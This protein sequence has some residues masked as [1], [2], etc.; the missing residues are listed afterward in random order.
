MNFQ[1]MFYTIYVRER[2]NSFNVCVQIFRRFINRC[3]K[4]EGRRDWV[5]GLRYGVRMNQMI[6][7]ESIELFKTYIILKY[8]FMTQNWFGECN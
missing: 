8:I 1:S 4:G 6:T 7:L 2:S 3:L 5:V